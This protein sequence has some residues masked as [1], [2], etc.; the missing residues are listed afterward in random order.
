MTILSTFSLNSNKN[1]KFNF[2]GGDLSSDS[3]LL[4]LKEFASKIGF[5]QVVQDNFHTNDPASFRIHSDKDNLLQTIYQ[6][7]A[8][9]DSDDC[10]DELILSSDVKLSW[11]TPSSRGAPLI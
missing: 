10:A 6:T 9:Y 3:G 4:L 1:V 5:E 2:S 11:N 8:D 7:I